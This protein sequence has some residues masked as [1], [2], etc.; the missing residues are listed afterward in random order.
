MKAGMSIDGAAARM[1]TLASGI[2]SEHP[3]TNAGW[4]VRLVSARG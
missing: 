4:T 2:E 3:D 1:Q